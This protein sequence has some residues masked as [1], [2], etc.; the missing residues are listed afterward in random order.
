MPH[1]SYQCKPKRQK[2]PFIECY[3]ASGLTLPACPRPCLRWL[4]PYVYIASEQ[5]QISLLSST[6]LHILLVVGPLQIVRHRVKRGIGL[7]DGDYQ[8]QLSLS[9]SLS[10]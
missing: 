7:H 9:L 6:A 5:Q 2:L 1:C 3:A 10:S 4:A 8:Q